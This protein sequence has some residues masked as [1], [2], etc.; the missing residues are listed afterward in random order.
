MTF[1]SRWLRWFWVWGLWA[2]LCLPTQARPL[3][4]LDAAHQ[5]VLLDDRG[6]YVLG[7]SLQR[8]VQETAQLPEASWSPTLVHGIYPLKAG[9]ALWIRFAAPPTPGKDRWYLE[10]PYPALDRASL[11][12][13]DAAGQWQ[14]QAAG[15]LVANRD[16]PRPHRYPVLALSVNTDTPTRYLLRIENA[17]GFS[18]HL[19]FVNDTYLL[20][21]EQA[22]SMTLGVYM[23]MALLACLAGL[24]GALVLRDP[25]YLYFGATSLFMGL[26]QIAWT[27]V[28]ALQFWPNQPYWAD[29]APTVLICLT[30]VSMLLLDATV[31]SV[32]Q[33][34]RWGRA[35]VGLLAAIG[36]ILAL[37]LLLTPSSLRFALVLPYLVAVPLV[38]AG[39]NVWTWRRG[40]RFALWMTLAGLPFAVA[41]ALAVMRYVEW[42]PASVLTEYGI[43]MSLG[44]VKP[45]IFSVLL[46]RS[47]T[48]RENQLRIRGLDQQ[49]AETGLVN[50]PTFNE[51]MARMIARTRRL[52][53]QGAV[54]VIDVMNAEQLHRDFGR[55]SSQDLPVLVAGRLLET[56]REI[57]TVA[58]LDSLRFGVLIEG[59]LTPQNAA[60]LAPRIIARCLMPYRH[61][62]PEW[63]VKLRLAYALVPADGEDAIVLLNDLQN[64]LSAPD[65]GKRTILTPR[66]L[67]RSRAAAIAAS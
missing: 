64:L 4:A 48:R 49:D 6:E 39:I 22:I 30:F 1:H 52:R 18:A 21:S 42:I 3:P 65:D 17:Q 57:D 55:S 11:F 5:P 26:T 28:G 29:R 67:H 62:H 40:E 56:L 46:V 8:T 60:I 54:M 53:M 31:V 36:G 13:Q 10:I 15:D 58:R 9:Q 19:R 37:L 51:R 14:E 12:T 7:P 25:V 43:L 41:L 16:W 24:A 63:V 50:A 59:P 23:G 44:L 32:F 27:G 66:D 20:A 47:Q 38:I 2:L 61:K 34:A 33:R 45:A 35:G